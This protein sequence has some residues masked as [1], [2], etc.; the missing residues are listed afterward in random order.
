MD[1]RFVDVTVGNVWSSPEKPRD[2]D[3]PSLFRPADIQG[4]ALPP[5]RR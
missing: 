3:A 4:M 1:I 2:L 5:G